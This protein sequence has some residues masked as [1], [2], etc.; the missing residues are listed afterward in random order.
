MKDYSVSPT[1]SHALELLLSD[2]LKRNEAVFR[3]IKMIDTIDSNCSIAL[4]GNWGS[5]KT[6]FIKQ[7]KLLMDF[8]NPQ[9]NLDN[10]VRKRI[11]TSSFREFAY[12][13]S[14]STVY[15]DAW[16]N[17]N[18]DNPILSLIY[19][20]IRSNQS[21]L[22]TEKKRSLL[23]TLGAIADAIS[24]RSI[25]DVLKQAKGTSLLEEL[26][27]FDDLHE[28][29]QDFID[30]LIHEKGNRLVVFVDELDRCKPDYAIRLLEC[31]KH[32]FDDE[33]LIFVFSISLFQLQHTIKC[34]YGYNFDATR[35]LD[36][37]FDLR[38][39]I[40]SINYDHLFKYKFPFIE[41]GYCYDE[42]CIRVIEYF[43]FSLR[44]VE[45]YMRLI[46]IA[47][48]QEAHSRESEAFSEQKGIQFAI[49][50]IIPIV[51]GLS[52]ADMTV[53]CDVL[54]GQNDKPIMDILSNMVPYL[55]M[56]LLTSQG[57]I[58]GLSEQ[59]TTE[60][61]K[62]RIS[63]VYKALFDTNI[64]KD[65]AKIRIGSMSFTNQSRSKVMQV[66]S[67]LSTYSEY[68]FADDT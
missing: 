62:K 1:D 3:F 37:F 42:T 60:L 30:S 56:D 26:K 27:S 47:A 33:R 14:Y 16:A 57:E 65:T 5:G 45:R 61:V 40:P 6:I 15:Y 59:E 25:S 52:M 50:H 49:S 54:S 39:S 43:S 28:L 8:M 4:D 24:G 19:A 22:D 48:Y 35:Y 18:H 11:E 38:I 46:R 32:Y 20:T 68:D 29:V 21:T 12:Y 66:M 31:V 67:L 10:D 34:Y 2:P 64:F 13:D 41:S 58:R 53:Y 23:N 9:S 63:E 51:I 7:V 44:E 55:R 36:K 17:D